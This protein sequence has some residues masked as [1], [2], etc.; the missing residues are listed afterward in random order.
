LWIAHKTVIAIS[1]KWQ[2]KNFPA[3]Q[4]QICHFYK[5]WQRNMPLGYSELCMV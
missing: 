1:A 4:F 2:T 5:I 3:T